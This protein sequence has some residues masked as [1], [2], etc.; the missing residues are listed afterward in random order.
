MV[1]P[2]YAQG[3][4]A[5]GVEPGSEYLLG[6]GIGAVEAEKHKASER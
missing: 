2:E 5:Q 4:W 1:H 6:L 3:L